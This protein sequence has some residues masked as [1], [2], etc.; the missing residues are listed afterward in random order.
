MCRENKATWLLFLD[1]HSCLKGKTRD[2][3][4]FFGSY[5]LLLLISSR[6]AASEITLLSHAAL[7][8]G[9]PKD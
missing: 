1:R 6:S 7:S 3:V 8:L 2:I 4:G 9:V 5:Q